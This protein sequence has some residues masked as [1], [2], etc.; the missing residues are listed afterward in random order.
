MNCI[1]THTQD[2]GSETHSNQHSVTR[3]RKPA[4]HQDALVR[5]VTQAVRTSRAL[6]SYPHP[7]LSRT[8][9]CH[10]GRQAGQLVA[11]DFYFYFYMSSKG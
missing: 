3:A 10:T 6:A 4:W 11:F 7:L 1:L 2:Q 5:S 8:G 9:M